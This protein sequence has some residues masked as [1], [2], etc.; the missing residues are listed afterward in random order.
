MVKLQVDQYEAMKGR[1]Y[2]YK[3]KTLLKKALQ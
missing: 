1:D 2:D 3:Y